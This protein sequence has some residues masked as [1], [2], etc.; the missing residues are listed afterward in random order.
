MRPVVATFARED[1][2]TYCR[3]DVTPAPGSPGVRVSW[4]LDPP[5]KDPGCGKAHHDGPRGHDGTVFVEVS[6]GVCTCTASYAGTVGGSGGAPAAVVRLIDQALDKDAA[7]LR[8]PR[9][10]AINTVRAAIALKTRAVAYL[11][12][13]AR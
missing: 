13:I 3:I 11:R 9:D 2:A 7:A 4:D 8:Q 1:F 6:D 5:E 10:T 12:D